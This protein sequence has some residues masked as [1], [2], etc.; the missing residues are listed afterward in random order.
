MA[1]PFPE[2]I[3]L[4]NFSSPGRDHRILCPDLLLL[5]FAGHLEIILRRRPIVVPLHLRI[6]CTSHGCKPPSSSFI[7]LLTLALSQVISIVR[8]AA[9]E[10]A[11]I[12]LWC[13]S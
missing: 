9:G 7:R 6:H 12:E 5:S 8:A 2:V 10:I 3:P 13:T 11:A 1:A 4:L